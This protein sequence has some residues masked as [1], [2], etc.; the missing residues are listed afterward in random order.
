MKYLHSG[1]LLFC[2][3]A[4]HA[5]NGR[6]DCQGLFDLFV[7]KELPIKMNCYIVIGFG[8]PYE[9]RQYKGTISLENPN[10]EVVFTKEFN[11]NDPAD[12]YKGHYLLKPDVILD[13]EGMWT[14][15]VVLKN[16]K[17]DPMWDFE[18]KFWTMIE[19]DAPPDP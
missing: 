6:I 1:Y 15:K 2:D 10:G 18:R 3:E 12:I 11:A 17:E 14:A 9:R 13:K 19:G 8:T 16:W 7:G 4:E 5:E